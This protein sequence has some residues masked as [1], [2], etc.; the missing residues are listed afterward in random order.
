MTADIRKLAVANDIAPDYQDAR[1][2]M[3]Q[4]ADDV[5][6]DLLAAIGISPEADPAL[7]ESAS[8]LPPVLVVTSVDGSAEIPVPHIAPG[9]E[10]AWRLG[11]EDGRSSEG[12][13]RVKSNA[14]LPLGMVPHGYHRLA[15][16]G[17]DNDTVLIV[18]PGACWLPPA[19]ADGERASGISLQLYLLRSEPNFGIGDF[20][21]LKRFAPLAARQGCDVIGVNPLHQMFLDA[22]EL[23]S[24]YSPASRYL[25]NILYIDLAALPEWTSAAVQAAVMAPAFI[26]R[27]A[28]CRAAP[29]VDYTAVTELKLAVLRAAFGTFETAA[30]PE[31]RAELD[32][33]V[34]AAGPRLRNASRFQI[35][36]STLG[37]DSAAWPSA[38]RDAAS[39]V[40]ARLVEQQ[41]GEVDFLNWTQWVADVQLAEAQRAC[42][43]SGMQI[44]L[45]RDLAVGCDRSGAET[46]SEPDAFLRGV[47][48]GAP[49]D[50]LNPAGQDWGLPPFNPAALRA[51]AYAPFRDLVRAN[52]RHAGGLR[53]DHVMGLKRLYCIPDGRP[54]SEGAYIAYPLDDML[55]I[56]ALESQRNE[57]IVV[58][59]DL[60]TVPPGF[61]ER[62]AEA[63][64]LSYRV[65]MFEQQDDGFIAPDAYPAKAV[66]V[67]GS[68][69]M[70]TLSGWLAGS[71]IDLKERLGLYPGSDEATRQRA[72]RARE[73]AGLQQVLSDEKAAI[74][75]EQF[76][77]SMHRFLGQTRSILAVAQ[78]DDLIGEAEPVNVPGTV[79]HPNWRR[80]Y[81][82]PL[83]ALDEAHPAWTAFADMHQHRRRPTS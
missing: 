71:D 44:G 45:Y 2:E 12:R 48:V 9:T 27:L 30:S 55:G 20:G 50:I 49:P 59:E 22:P 73:L 79:D 54:A 76:A 52:M 56:I 61:R 18:S 33:F 41:S 80:K 16:A 81:Q 74:A 77:S 67:A 75:P 17:A 28:Q 42:A 83:E 34:T 46:W 37:P 35:L 21:D 40:V 14:T 57:C 69:D 5:L 65:V 82:A 11:L 53:I 3:V 24:P 66:A 13:T 43:Q 60:G 8:A 31:R 39:D 7:R 29:L 23:A 26:A 32:A 10:V 25:L 70:A 62:L 15:V 72:D 51:Q 4:V 47:S 38:Y 64:I 19:L 68:H 36:R 6:A 58:G 1:G 63:N 78:L